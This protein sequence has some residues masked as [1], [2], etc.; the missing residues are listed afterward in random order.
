[1]ARGFKWQ[2]D[3][4]R[5]LEH[6]QKR[7]GDW[8]SQKTQDR[9][10]RMVEN[11]AFKLEQDRAKIDKELRKFAENYDHEQRARM[12]LA[13]GAGLEDVFSEPRNVDHIVEYKRLR[14]EDRDWELIK[15]TTRPPVGVWWRNRRGMFLEPIKQDD[16][17]WNRFVKAIGRVFRKPVSTECEGGQEPPTGD[18]YTEARVP[19]PFVVVKKRKKAV[20]PS[21]SSDPPDTPA[22][23]LKKR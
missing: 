21:I 16:G 20:G 8:E 18:S 12:L 3:S 13:I 22:K 23:I 19:N 14:K 10:R 11:A 4:E 7:G 17:P 15:E 6:Q 1:M 2:T 9:R 5:W